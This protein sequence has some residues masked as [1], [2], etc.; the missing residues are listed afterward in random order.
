MLNK[1][2]L[3]SLVVFQA[4][5]ILIAIIAI[6]LGIYYKYNNNNSQKPVIESIN[7]DNVTMFDENHYQQKIIKNNQV[8]FQIIEINTNTLKKEIIIEK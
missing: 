4:I 8:I 6:I 5:L 3:L 2:F 7:L 1:K